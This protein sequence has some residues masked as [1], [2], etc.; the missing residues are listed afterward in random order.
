MPYRCTVQPT[1]EPVTLG[2]MRDQL[3]VDTITEDSLL[4]LYVSAAR[5]R[6]ERE[7]G[8]AIVSQTWQ[9]TADGFP[10]V[11]PCGRW[12]FGELLCPHPHVIIVPR[13]PLRSV[14][15]IQYVDADG[16]TQTLDPSNYIVDTVSE[17]GRIAPAFG[18]TW[19]AT[20]HQINAV[21]ITFVCGF[22]V[23]TGGGGFD[24]DPPDDLTNAIRLLAAHYYV[25]RDADA[26]TPRAVTDVFAN[27][28][29]FLPR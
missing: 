21:T 23:P 18:K 2:E 5:Q 15:S 26:P 29:V 6:A 24:V 4:S 20:R 7:T 3:R 10:H 25:A 27:R 12:W 16:A 13:P 22:S 9:M 19:P 8:R 1:A 28:R 11:R 17:P 14:T